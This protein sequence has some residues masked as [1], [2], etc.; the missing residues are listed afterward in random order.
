MSAILSILGSALAVP[1]RGRLLDKASGS[2]DR[3]AT[4]ACVRSLAE[5][6]GFLRRLH[7]LEDRRS[8]DDEQQEAKHVGTHLECVF[9]VL[10]PPRGDLAAL[11]HVALIRV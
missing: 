6:I 9:V 11:V 3:L 7:D 1:P 5:G 8:D 10:L 4:S 2:G